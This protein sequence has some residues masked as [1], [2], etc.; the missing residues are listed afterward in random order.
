MDY[1]NNISEDD[2]EMMVKSPMAPLTRE[3]LACE[4]KLISTLF[5]SLLSVSSL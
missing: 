3:L 5:V 1:K 2:E 4:R